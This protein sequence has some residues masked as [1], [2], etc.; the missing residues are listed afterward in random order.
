M[1]KNDKNLVENF[2]AGDDSAFESLLK[3]Y[4][5]PIYNFL[6]Q[7]T[8]D[9]SA[10]PD[11]TQI[12]F[13]KAWKNLRRFDPRR[14]RFATLRGRQNK[15]LAPYRTEGSGSGFKVWLFAIAKNT[16]YDHF[17]K[18]KTL[19]FSFFENNEGHNKLEEIEEDKLLPDEILERQDIIREL[20]E[21]LKELPKNYRIILLMRYKDDLTITE[22]SEII[23]VPY[24]TLK[25]RHQRALAALRKKFLEK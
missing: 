5:K 6:Y 22:I 14:S 23:G 19:P 11:L 16:A 9:R 25:S 1:Q 18:K 3:R 7:L 24:N 13:I 8:G 15:S 10:L 4:L 21:K 17:K 20:E 2:L 12:T